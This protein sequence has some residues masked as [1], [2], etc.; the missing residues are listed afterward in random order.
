MALF[1]VHRRPPEV[2]QEHILDRRVRPQVAVFLDRA[3]IVEHKATVEAVVVAQ[4]A[5]QRYYR[6]VQV[7]GGHFDFFGFHSFTST[8]F[9]LLIFYKIFPSLFA[10]FLTYFPFLSQKQHLR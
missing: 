10:L 2:V 8:F 7:V 9:F 3:D 5:G 1:L 6:P 4:D